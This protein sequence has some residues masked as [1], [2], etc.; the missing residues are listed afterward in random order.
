MNDIH[1]MKA[2]ARKNSITPSA[3]L[4]AAVIMKMKKKEKA[5]LRC[6]DNARRVVLMYSKRY[7]RC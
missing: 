6:I 7:S 5:N 3:R 1:R 4:V 2:A